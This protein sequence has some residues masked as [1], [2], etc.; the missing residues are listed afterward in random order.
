MVDIGHSADIARSMG[1][2]T[3]VPRRAY[4]LAGRKQRA[5]DFT[6]RELAVLF[7]VLA[8]ITSIP[9]ALFP[10]PPLADYINHLSRMHVIAT[11]DADPD[12]SR[13]YEINWQ[14]IPNLVMDLFVPTL[15]RVMD[16]YLAGQIYTI[17]SFVL[18]LS[19]T[20]ALNRQLYGHWSV[21]PMIAF[22]LL[23]NNIF[24]VGTMNY[25]FG[26][27]LSLWA[28]AVWVWLRERGILLR[29][30][31][32]TLFVLA[33]FFCHLFAVGLYGLGI[34]SFELFRLWEQYPRRSRKLL[35]RKLL[36]RKLLDRKLLDR[37]RSDQKLSGDAIGNRPLPLLVDFVASGLPFLPVVPL[38]MM[39]PTWGL[40]A[41]YQ[42]E[43]NGKLDGLIYVIEVYSHFA[44]FLLTGIVAFAAGWGMRHRALRFHA[45]GWALLV[46]GGLVYL[47]MPRVIF[48]TFMADQRMPISIAFM[49]I[50]CAHLNLRHDYV[51]R[52]FATVLV[53]LLAVR[54]FEVQTV[55]SD[56][57][58]STVSFRDSIRHIDRGS[59]VLVAYADP[60][61]GDDVRDLGL[62]HAACAAIIERS[63]LVTTAFTVVGKQILHVRDDY[64]ARVDTTDGTPPSVHQLLNVIEEPNTPA[65]GYWGKW[66]SDYDYV[67][68]LF[69][70]ANYQNPDPG[71]LT[72][73][74]AGE[75][76]MLYR[77]HPQIADSGESL[78]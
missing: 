36:D 62:V 19:G 41:T 52:G 51:R 57:S 55:W 49:V 58:R 21:L 63:A 18:I 7:I 12:L 74:Y 64:R 54:V 25:V 20:L 37:K 73:I 67:Y 30:A 3:A 32:S 23:Y 69:T 38:L 71:R 35:D 11:I 6:N 78:D 77:I 70:D 60:D 75:R 42:W 68:V 34:L 47:A 59:K 28:L 16:V 39:S 53:L 27:G 44:A 22:P 61:N 29:L 17:T 45:L 48:E 24:L 13:F 46:V 56:L 1:V 5:A 66:N 31:V 50:A 15:E 4:I 76:F 65:A 40:R 10:W 26:I 2:R 72:A 43:L 33:L 14:I 8:A 9:I